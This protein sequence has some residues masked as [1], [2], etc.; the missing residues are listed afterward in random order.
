[1]GVL[2][3]VDNLASTMGIW[4][5]AYRGALPEGDGGVAGGGGRVADRQ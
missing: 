1:M 3:C 4:M 5:C 2:R